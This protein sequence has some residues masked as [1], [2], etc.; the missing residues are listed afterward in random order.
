[1][2]KRKT[3]VVSQTPC[4]STAHKK[5]ACMRCK[6]FEFLHK[7]LLVRL[8]MHQIQDHL[9]CLAI[10]CKTVRI[11][12]ITWKRWIL[13]NEGVGGRSRDAGGRRAGAGAGD[14]VRVSAGTGPAAETLGSLTASEEEDSAQ[15]MTPVRYLLF[16]LGTICRGGS[17]SS[18]PYKCIF[19]G[20]SWSNRPYK[21]F[22]FF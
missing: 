17:W 3:S 2:D 16:I 18:R 7:I 12:F 10:Q 11:R 6:N 9:N 15:T 19:R 20:G 8:E 4:C 5:W 22:L 21:Y 1:M 14:R 13:E